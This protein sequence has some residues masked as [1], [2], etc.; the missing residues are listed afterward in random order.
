M[1]TP[2]NS[3][4]AVPEAARPKPLY[5]AE[6]LPEE[7][8]EVI[9][10]LGW[11]PTDVRLMPGTS[12]PERQT[13]CLAWFEGLMAGS[14][15]KAASNLAILE[16]EAKA[17]GLTALKE[18]PKEEEKGLEDETVDEI[19]GAV[20]SRRG[21]MSLDTKPKKGKKAPAQATSSPEGQGTD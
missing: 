14:I 15:D 2:A 6:V 19:L 13:R 3:W 12:L 18:I 21:S 1:K 5:L 8:L 9:V 16:L 20:V 11:A 4:P 17:C 7:E 10:G